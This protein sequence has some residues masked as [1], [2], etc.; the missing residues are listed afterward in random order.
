MRLGYFPGFN[1]GDAVLISCDPGDIA[2]LRSLL[3][4]ASKSDAPVSVHEHGTV[5]AA[6]PV[7]LIAARTGVLVRPGDRRFTWRVD[8][9]YP[10]VDGLLEG[11]QP[12]AAGHQYFG[13]DRTTAV[14]MVSVGE[15]DA[16]WWEERV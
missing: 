7:E 14:L 11:L 8:S 12:A 1:G 3:R 15:Y 4:R 16:N 10:N 2:T 6:H 13:L 5:S 9:T